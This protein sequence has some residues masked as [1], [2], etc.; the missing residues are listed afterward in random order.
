L[1]PRWASFEPT[2]VKFSWKARPAAAAFSGLSFRRVKKPPAS[3]SR[4]PHNEDQ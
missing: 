2:A 4:I 3:Q 1:Q